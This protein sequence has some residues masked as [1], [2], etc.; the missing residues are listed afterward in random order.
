MPTS[1]STMD[2]LCSRTLLPASKA[3]TPN[4]PPRTSRKESSDSVL[5]ENVWCEF[6][7]GLTTVCDDPDPTTAT[8][9]GTTISGSTNTPGPTETT[10]RFEA[11]GWPAREAMAAAT[12]LNSPRPGFSLLTTT[13]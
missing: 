9:D 12:L 4:E 8:Q 11:D 6:E 10:K 3:T 2:T 5:R 1:Q 13:I 7:S